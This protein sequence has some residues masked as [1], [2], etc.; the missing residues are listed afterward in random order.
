MTEPGSPRLP[1]SGL[2]N[3]DQ[4]RSD[5]AIFLVYPF[6]IEESTGNATRKS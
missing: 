5:A 2:P 3:E 4:T 6:G 1:Q